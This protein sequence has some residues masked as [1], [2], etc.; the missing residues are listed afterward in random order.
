M[1]YFCSPCRKVIPDGTR[2]EHWTKED[3][4]AGYFCSCGRE[5]LAPG[6]D[7]HCMECH[8]DFTKMAEGGAMVGDREAF[9]AH[10]HP[11]IK[12]T[13]VRGRAKR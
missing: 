11:L 10:E 12:K 9:Y 2:C 6:W 13:P 7:W 1:S 4:L 5:G 8:Q 3:W